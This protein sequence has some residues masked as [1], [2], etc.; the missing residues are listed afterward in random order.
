MNGLSNSRQLPNQHLIQKASVGKRIGAFLLDIFIFVP[1]LMFPF[2]FML[3]FT[4]LSGGLSDTVIRAINIVFMIIVCFR[5]TIKGQSI[6]KRIFGI[7]VRDVYDN[8]TIPSIPKLFLRQ[9]L[10]FIWPI[11]FLVLAFS[12]DNRKIGDRIASTGVYDLRKYKEYL[13]YVKCMEYMKQ[14]QS[15]V[16]LPDSEYQFP[17]IKPRK[18]QKIKIAMIVIGALLTFSILIGTFIFGIASMLRNHPS[19]HIATEAIKTNP[20]IVALIG[21]IEGFGLMPT[22]N[23]STSSSRG[24]ANFNIRA[25]GT[26]GQVRVFVELQMRDGGDW[27]IVRFNFVQIR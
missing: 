13:H 12:S 6:G 15:I 23:L 5:D 16:H 21:E 20:E 7:G 11:E 14:A 22:G 4:G 9:I 27:E 17:T 24:D 1:I 25:I 18:S 19:Y 8:F 26:Y 2:S 3:M 10:S